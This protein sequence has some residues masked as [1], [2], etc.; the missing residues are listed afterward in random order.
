MNRC[1]YTLVNHSK[2]IKPINYRSPSSSLL[3]SNLGEEMLYHKYFKNSSTKITNFK[4][5]PKQLVK[6]K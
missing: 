3:I 5:I 6:I 4:P 1:V 2:P